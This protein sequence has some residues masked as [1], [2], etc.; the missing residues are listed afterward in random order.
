MHTVY[1]YI[2]EASL[3][4]NFGWPGRFCAKDFEGAHICLGNVG[5]GREQIR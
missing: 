3:V 1:D 2:R 5:E 4:R